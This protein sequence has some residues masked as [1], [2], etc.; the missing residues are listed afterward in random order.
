MRSTFLLLINFLVFSQSLLAKVNDAVPEK[1]QAVNSIT[2][3]NTSNYGNKRLMYPVKQGGV[4]LASN[5]KSFT[6]T[7]IEPTITFIREGA[8]YKVYNLS[9]LNSDPVGI[10]F[11]VLPVGNYYIDSFY[12]GN[13]S[14]ALRSQNLFRAKFK[15]HPGVVE[16]LGRIK[17]TVSPDSNFN[18]KVSDF[19]IEDV[20]S[21]RKLKGNVPVAKCILN[22]GSG[23]YCL[24]SKEKSH[25]SS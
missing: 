23:G 3:H 8:P 15:V 10:H 17:I 13:D 21:F 4:I 19:Y 7:D 5:N 9:L 25:E 1:M 22:F 14:L 16:Y 24:K 11:M 6:D 2:A 20:S 12:N 18:F